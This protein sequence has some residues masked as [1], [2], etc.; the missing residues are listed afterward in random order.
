[1]LPG[2]IVGVGHHARKPLRQ[3]IDIGVALLKVLIPRPSTNGGFIDDVVGPLDGQ[4]LL[5]TWG[6]RLRQIHSQHRA[7]YGV[8]YAL[9]IAACNLLNLKAIIVVADRVMSSQSL[10][11]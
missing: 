3:E 10:K 6:K 7:D 8:G 2:R 1:M 5:C 11:A 9:T 4:G